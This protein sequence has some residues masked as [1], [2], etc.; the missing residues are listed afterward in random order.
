M[1]PLLALLRSLELHIA[2][3]GP[4]PTVRN[5]KCRSQT[6]SR[7]TTCRY[8][9]APWAGRGR[10]RGAW[11]RWQMMRRCR[12]GN[13][14]SCRRVPSGSA[15][16]H[17][18]LIQRRSCGEVEGRNARPASSAP[19][20][21]VL[22]G[23]GSYGVLPSCWTLRAKGNGAHRVLCHCPT[24]A[25]RWAALRTSLRRGAARAGGGSGATGRGVRARL[26]A[27]FRC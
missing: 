7:M 3:P 12:C 17:R 23:R 8:W 25:C 21:P 14:S 2:N 4:C 9:R 26:T 15:L 11:R 1:H 18:G 27:T 20:Q 22:P 24:P 10:P 19:Q 16:L 5:C 13:E 6:T